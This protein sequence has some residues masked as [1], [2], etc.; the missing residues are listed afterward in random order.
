MVTQQSEGRCRS[1]NNIIDLLFLSVKA[2]PIVSIEQIWLN[3]E[4]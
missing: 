3:V 2:L 1:F 4:V